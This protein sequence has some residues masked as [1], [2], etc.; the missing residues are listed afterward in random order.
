MPFFVNYKTD[1]KFKVFDNSHHPN[2][3]ASQN[4]YLCHKLILVHIH[5]QHHNRLHFRRT[6][7]F[8]LHNT[9]LHHNISPLKNKL[10]VNCKSSFIEYLTCG[11]IEEFFAQP[12]HFGICS[13]ARNLI[14]CSN[15]QKCNFVTFCIVGNF[16]A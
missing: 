3:K 5:D 8:Q 9:N 1:F 4:N 14:N 7:H 12:N 11:H 6:T 10:F 13:V 16:K 15:V 2:Q